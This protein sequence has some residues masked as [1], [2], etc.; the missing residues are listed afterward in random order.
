MTRILTI[1]KFKMKQKHLII[2]LIQIDDL[3]QYYVLLYRLT[4]KHTL[5][6]DYSTYKILSE[7]NQGWSIWKQH[8]T[9]KFVSFKPGFLVMVRTNAC[10]QMSFLSSRETTCNT[11]YK[12]YSNYATQQLRNRGQTLQNKGTSGHNVIGLQQGPYIKPTLP[13][14]CLTVKDGHRCQYDDTDTEMWNDVVLTIMTAF[15]ESDDKHFEEF[16]VESK[17]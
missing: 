6:K 8:L 15:Y 10:V 4:Q 2:N 3:Y 5:N 13:R 17:F 12:Y 9:W 16:G 7:T 1:I 14:Q 11:P